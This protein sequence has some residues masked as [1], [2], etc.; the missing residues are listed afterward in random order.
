MIELNK[1]IYWGLKN[2]HDTHKFI[3]EAFIKAWKHL[4][5]DVYWVN[6]IEELTT[7]NIDFSKCLVWYSYTGV[8]AQPPPIKKD[9][10]Y[11]HH[12]A[13]DFE[14]KVINTI[15]KEYILRQQVYATT[16]TSEYDILLQSQYSSFNI[17]HNML[18]M[19]WGTNL[20]PHEIDENIKNLENM[21][22]KP[23]CGHIGSTGGAW[24]K[25]YNTFR[26]ELKQQ[27]NIEMIQAGPELTGLVP[28]NK[29]IDF[30][31]SCMIVPSLQFKWQ[32][33]VR[34]IPCRIFKTISY[35][36][37][38]ITNNIGV[39]E[40]FDKKVLYSDNLKKL[41]EMSVEFE[42]NPRKHQ[43]IKDLMVDVR[44]NHTYISRVNLVIDVL[45]EYKNVKINN[46]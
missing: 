40:L 27:Y 41:V 22:I 25:P 39:Y 2:T 5:Y 37:M 1:I 7:N 23:I 14:K 20:L 29:M 31:K 3:F 16:T 28:E 4:N 13:D 17:R 42:K 19:P 30:L 11:I 33:D 15:G 43:I 46:E 8:R 6:S 10:F 26:Q 18:I 35:G 21:K 34:Y 12:N 38:G 32:R 24:G 36:K 45:K 9:N 44:D